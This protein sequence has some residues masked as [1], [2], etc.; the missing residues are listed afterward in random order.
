MEKV[1]A[2]ENLSQMILL[3]EQKQALELQALHRQ[4]DIIHESI[5]P[6]NIAK[7]AFYSLTT[8]SNFKN[9]ILQTVVSIASGYLSKK[10]VTGSSQNSFKK[11]LG[12]VLQ[13]AVTTLVAKRSTI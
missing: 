9:K 1:N 10:L 7:S 2:T 8:S 3:L 5:M 11:I 13:F 4:Y 12:T 6:L